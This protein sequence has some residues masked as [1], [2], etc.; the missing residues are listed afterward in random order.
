MSNVNL[1]GSYVQENR[2][3]L[4]TEK[5][6][7]VTPAIVGE[8]MA[9]NGMVLST[10]ST[11]RAKH[12]DKVDFQKTMARYRDTNEVLPGIHLDLLYNS[13]HMGRGV[14]ELY[15][16]IYRVICTNG[17]VAGAAFHRGAVRH[18]G[19]TFNSLSLA[20]QTA[21][22]KR[23]ELTDLIARMQATQL[24]TERVKFLVD[25]AVKLLVPDTAVNVRSSLT[26]VR[27]ADDASNDLFTVFNRIQENGIAG[28]VAYDLI[29][30]DTERGTHTVRH[31]TARRIKANTQRDLEYNQGLFD[32][33]SKLA[34]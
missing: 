27:R 29:Q 7:V 13:K 34:A 26:L 5:F 9:E 14:D 16:G 24:D 31:M 19:D 4:V 11:G 3:A 30:T 12:L 32:L 18:S 28:R 10:L 15:V 22:T 8:V 20:I 21:L 6:N 25:G 2:H 17:M 33:A 1:S 23:L